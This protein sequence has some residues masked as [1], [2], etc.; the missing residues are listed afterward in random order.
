MYNSIQK[1]KN[2]NLQLCESS[3][4]PVKKKTKLKSVCKTRKWFYHCR[5]ESLAMMNALD[6][7][8]FK[9]CERYTKYVRTSRRLS[10]WN[11]DRFSKMHENYRE[12][13]QVFRLAK[14]HDKKLVKGIAEAIANKSDTSFLYEKKKFSSKKDQKIEGKP[15]KSYLN[16]QTSKAALFS[17]LESFDV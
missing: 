1:P 14:L 6:E 12:I 3:C 17:Y 7:F 4:R 5:N 2:F 16:P 11:Y 8:V 15:I 10:L 9:T 13:I